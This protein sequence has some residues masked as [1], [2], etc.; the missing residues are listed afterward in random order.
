MRYFAGRLS[1]NRYDAEPSFDDALGTAIRWGLRRRVANAAPS[2]EVW[3][4]I[5]QRVCADEGVA[6]GEA[7]NFVVGSRGTV[8]LI[9]FARLRRVAGRLHRLCAATWNVLDEH[10]L[11]SEMMWGPET[12][13]TRFR[14]APH[15]VISWPMC[16]QMLPIF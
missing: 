14:S 8:E 2:A 4:R 7:Q 11:S 15:C 9:K 16:G 13:G 12:K 3:A 6:T 10:T 1:L 5:K